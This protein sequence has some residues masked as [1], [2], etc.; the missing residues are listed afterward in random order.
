M[1][2]FNAGVVIPESIGTTLRTE[3]SYSG[4]LYSETAVYFDQAAKKNVRVSVGGG[5]A[6]QGPVGQYRLGAEAGDKAHVFCVIDAP[7]S[8]ALTAREA[9][10]AAKQR[11]ERLSKVSDL[12]AFRQQCIAA[13]KAIG[14]SSPRLMYRLYKAWGKNQALAQAAFKL[15]ISAA[16]G[17]LRSEFRMSIARQILEW[18]ADEQVGNPHKFQ[19]PLS[20]KQR[21]ILLEMD[22]PFRR[23]YRR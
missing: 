20:P 12:R 9:E 13:A 19:A 16:G 4:D 18:V 7:A 11:A 14:L 8:L 17:K 15:I 23:G 1:P 21:S 10:N 3:I 22:K 5:W 6:D 2:I